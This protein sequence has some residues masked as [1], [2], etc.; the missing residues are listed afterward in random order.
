MNPINRVTT[1]VKPHIKPVTSSLCRSNLRQKG[2]N[3]L[4][5]NYLFIRGKQ[6]G[7][8]LKNTSMYDP[9]HYSMNNTLMGTWNLGKANFK[10]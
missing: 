8:E 2:S 10:K 1:T 5:I 7:G 3:Q 9:K 4:E 6:A